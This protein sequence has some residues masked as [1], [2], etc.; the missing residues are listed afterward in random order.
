M[1]G[2]IRIGGRTLPWLASGALGVGA[3]RHQLGGLSTRGVRVSEHPQ[4]CRLRVSG[5]GGLKLEAEASVSGESAAGWRY[6]GPSGDGRDVV[7]CSVAAL[8]LTVR[9]PGERKPLSL[10]SPH[11]GAYELGMRERDHGVPLAPFADG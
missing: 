5:E 2:R 7:N 4:G 3:R 1:L 10:H 9:L 11:G 6:G 8:D